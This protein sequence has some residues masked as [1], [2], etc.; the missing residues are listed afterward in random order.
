M[1]DDLTI[2][3]TLHEFGAWAFWDYAAAAPYVN[4][5]V[6]P[7]DQ[8]NKD[9]V[10]FSMHKFVGG[11]QTPGILVAKKKLFGNQVPHACGGGTVV[12][13]TESGHQYIKVFYVKQFN[14]ISLKVFNLKI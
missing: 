2:T 3:A 4:I 5:D 6:N 10:Y 14:N 7:G 1:N 9:A 12:F 11:V 8:F 13:V